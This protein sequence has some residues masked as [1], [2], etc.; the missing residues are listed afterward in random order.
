MVCGK[1][2]PL[3]TVYGEDVPST[4]VEVGMILLGSWLSPFLWFHGLYSSCEACSKCLYALGH[5]ARPNPEVE[6]EG[7]FG[8]VSCIRWY[9]VGHKHEGTFC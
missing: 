6:T 4:W 1:N 7:I 9:F 3:Q 5:I 2:Q 8:K